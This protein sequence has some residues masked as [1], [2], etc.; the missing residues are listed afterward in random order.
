MLASW[1]DADAGSRVRAGEVLSQ[2]KAKLEH[3]AWLGWVEAHVPYKTRWVQVTMELAAW[4]QDNPAMF[5]RVRGLGSE[6]ATELMRLRLDQLETLLARREHVVP[7]TGRRV[8][9]AALTVAELREVLKALTGKG[10]TGAEGAFDALIKE[11]Q[12]SAKKAIA[13]IQWLIAN[14]GAVSPEVVE[15]LH[16]DLAHWLGELEEAFGLEGDDP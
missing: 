5:G 6:K 16:D 15:D 12:G 8:P 1:N 2:A 14:K 9:L 13:S 3:G 4:S 11:A 7:S 10:P